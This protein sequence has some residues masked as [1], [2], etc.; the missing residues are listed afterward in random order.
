ML[1]DE[2][3][4][5]VMKRLL[6]AIA[7]LVCGAILVIP[8]VAH[9]DETSF[10][11]SFNSF[12]E[13]YNSLIYLGVAFGLVSVVLAVASF[14]GCRRYSKRRSTF[15][16]VISLGLCSVSIVCIMWSIVMDVHEGDWQ[17]LVDTAFYWSVCF[18]C[19]VAF[20]M[21]VG[22]TSLINSAKT[23]VR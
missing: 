23:V 6:S 19:M 15:T 4:R 22:L 8:S 14:I 3:G 10:Y 20:N 21:L 5:L 12:E 2:D 16:V 9:A 17:S 13:L 1:S 7:C 11:A 18:T